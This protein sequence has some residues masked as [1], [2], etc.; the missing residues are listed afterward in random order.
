MKAHFGFCNV[1]Y[2][3]CKFLHPPIATMIPV[4]TKQ[5]MPESHESR[6]HNILENEYLTH[7]NLQVHIQKAYFHNINGVKL[8]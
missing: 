5:R 1:Y 8:R 6:K 3:H 7:T 4:T 2:N